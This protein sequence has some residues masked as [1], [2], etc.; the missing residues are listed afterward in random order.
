MIQ[1]TVESYM[2]IKNKIKAHQDV[3]SQ[4]RKE[5][6]VLAKEIRDYMNQHDEEGLKVDDCIISLNRT[7]K[8]IVVPPKQYKNKVG[9]LLKSRGISSDSLVEDILNAK[10][11]QV[12]Q[13]QKLRLLRPK[14]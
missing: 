12:V 14:K 9:D 5:E 10:V 1:N 3:L 8:K 6:K 7:E 4:L 13:E 11:D 2:E